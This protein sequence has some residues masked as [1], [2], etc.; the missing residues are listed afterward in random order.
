MV[1]TIDSQSLIAGGPA[2]TVSASGVSLGPDGHSIVISWSVTKDASAW[3]GNS[4]ASGTSRKS[5]S[6]SASRRWWKSRG[7]TIEFMVSGRIY[8]A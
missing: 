7:N 3:L 5:G 8:T 4:G 1:Y 6:V 2:T